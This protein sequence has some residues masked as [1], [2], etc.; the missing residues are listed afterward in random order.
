M[1]YYPKSSDQPG[2]F[3]A[4][5]SGS[6]DQKAMRNVVVRCISSPATWADS[7]GH[8]CYTYEQ[9]RWCTTYGAP[10]IGWQ[11]SWGKLTDFVP[12]TGISATAACCACGGGMATLQNEKGTTPL[13]QKR[14]QAAADRIP[15]QDGRLDGRPGPPALAA[16]ADRIP[17][18]ASPVAPEDRIPL[19]YAR[20]F[21]EVAAQEARPGLMGMSARFFSFPPDDDCAK[22]SASRI[23]RGINYGT[24]VGGQVNT[25]DR[26]HFSALQIGESAT[27]KTNSSAGRGHYWA[28][29]SGTLQ[30]LRQGEYTFD[31]DV[32]WDTDSALKIDG[33]KI[34]TD[35]QCRKAKD[36]TSC[37]AKGCVVDGETGVTTISVIVV[38]VVIIIIII[39]IMIMIM[40]VSSSIISAVVDVYG[41]LVHYTV[42]HTVVYNN[43][44]EFTIPL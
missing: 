22:P 32:G 3:P 34:L 19:S 1:V 24:N 14:I 37:N 20:Y 33:V 4:H 9:N 23:D 28:I 2:A 30:T 29:W 21:Q 27:T 18:R 17:L 41:M 6:S 11:S 31:L 40:T 43:L 44:L 8:D 15:D 13:A 36:E 38:F 5:E 42:K 26:M 16:P 35:G 7:R 25:L 12:F 10:G 39:M